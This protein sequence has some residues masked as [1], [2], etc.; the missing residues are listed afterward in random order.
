[1]IAASTFA[2]SPVVIR[3]GSTAQGKKIPADFVGESFETASILMNHGGVKGYLFDSSDTQL[4][5]LFKN[6]GIKS[7]RIGGASVD[8]EEINPT[9]DDIDALFRFAKETDVNVIYSFRLLNGNPQENA[10]TAK[11]IWSKYRP[12]LNSFAIGN[13]PDWHSFHM[14]DPEI[15]EATPGVPGTAFPSYLAKW[16]RFAKAILDSV[17]E[18]KFSGPNSGSNFPVTGSKNTGLNDKSWTENFIDS[19]KNSG[20]ISF[21]TQHNYVGQS[22]NGKTVNQVIGMML[23]AEWDTVEYPAVY[24]ASC[25]PALAAGYPFRL[26]ESN[27]FSEGIDG[28][29]NTFATALF[30]LDYLH[31]WSQR[32]AAGINFH[33]TQWR[34]N[35]TIHPDA[36]DRLQINPMGYGMTAFS[37]GGRGTVIPISISNPD[38]IDLTAY[39]V[40]DSAA[41]FVTVINRS[42]GDSGRTA[43]VIITGPTGVTNAFVMTMTV[44]NGDV[45]AKSGM[46]LG[47]ESIENDKA[48]QGNWTSF[49]SIKA[50]TIKCSVAPASAS[51]IKILL[52]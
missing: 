41:L 30:A 28:A 51:I 29:S 31:W 21:F 10:S 49:D 50:G 6:L 16:R 52:R 36:N 38:S 24:Y 11:Y 44:P 8:R 3:V 22:T 45:Y 9:R 13:E 39:A 1:M 47:G 33:T 2:Q 34:F 14:R 25:A 32:S 5:T 40:R 42:H 19:E 35:G 18:V 46:T 26:T 37:V 17:P 15:F 27:S 12:Y 20:I 4:I 23:S 7:L 43:T 48:W